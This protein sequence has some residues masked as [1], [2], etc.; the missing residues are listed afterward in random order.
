M[1]CFFFSGEDYFAKSDYVKIAP[2]ITPMM[3]THQGMNSFLI[4]NQ[5]I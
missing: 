4:V 1:H 2:K 3:K 5:F